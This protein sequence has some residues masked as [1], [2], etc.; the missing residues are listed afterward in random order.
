MQGEIGGDGI[1]PR[2][3]ARCESREDAIK[4]LLRAT[5]LGST[6][7]ESNDGR[8]NWEK[9]KLPDDGAIDDETEEPEHLQVIFSHHR[10][11]VG[12]EGVQSRFD[13]QGFPIACIGNRLPQES[14]PNGHHDPDSGRL[15][16]I[17]AFSNR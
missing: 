2:F 6:N 3:D 7:D 10:R 11:L 17:N 1:V 12:Y 5:Q 8:G 9:R 13:R 4:E 15:S 16:A 14:L